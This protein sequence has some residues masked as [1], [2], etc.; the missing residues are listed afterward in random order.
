MSEPKP[1][2]CKECGSI[3]GWQDENGLNV[4]LDAV[5]RYTVPTKTEEIWVTCKQCA[6]VQIWRARAELRQS[7]LGGRW[8]TRENPKDSG[9]E[10][11]PKPRREL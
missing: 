4:Q 7:L 10:T 2:R 9:P 6:S 11:P 1:W 5:E 3:L 8:R